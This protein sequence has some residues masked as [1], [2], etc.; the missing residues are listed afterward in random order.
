M[1]AFDPTDEVIRPKN[2][3]HPNLH[4]YNI[5]IGAENGYVNSDSSTGKDPIELKTLDTL[6]KE[7]GDYGKRIT[8][9]KLDVEGFE[10]LCMK[11]WLK[12]GVVRFIDQLGIE[13]H[14]GSSNYH[15]GVLKGVLNFFRKIL[16][17]QNLY[18][19]EYNPN[20]CVGKSYDK[21]KKY[22]AYHDLLFVRN[23]FG[24]F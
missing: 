12:S 13:M 8:Y 3:Y 23:N 11:Q 10:I 4:Y 24:Q 2:S 21:M 15:N 5:G 16:D 14:T 7:N 22:Y 6:L 18:L 9:L 17:K 19:V 1:R 20:L